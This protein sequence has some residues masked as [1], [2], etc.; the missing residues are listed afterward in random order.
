MANWKKK[1]AGFIVFKNRASGE[2]FFCDI[3]HNNSEKRELLDKYKLLNFETEEYI[4]NFANNEEI[5]NAVEIYK[6]KNGGN[7]EFFNESEK[8]EH[9]DDLG[10]EPH[11]TVSLEVFLRNWNK[12]K[13]LSDHLYTE[14]EINEL[15]ENGVTGVFPCVNGVV[16]TEEIQRLYSK[17]MLWKMSE[18]VL[19]MAGIVFYNLTNKQPI[20]N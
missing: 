11:L 3:F 12:A 5:L 10:D 2:Q 8:E 15:K 4:G 6:L 20:Y 1:E 16:G 18:K 19:F 14:E 17:P 13:E 9:W 7:R